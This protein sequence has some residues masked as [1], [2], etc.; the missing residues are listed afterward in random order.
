MQE[1]WKKTKK[2]TYQVRAWGDGVRS[3]EIDKKSQKTSKTNTRGRINKIRNIE[4][5]W[6]SDSVSHHREY[7]TTCEWNDMFHFDTAIKWKRSGHA[8]R[9]VLVLRRGNVKK[10][11]FLGWSMSSGPSLGGWQ[12]VLSHRLRCHAARRRHW[13]WSR[14]KDLERRMERTRP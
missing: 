8:R 7:K 13:E 4:E 12:M 11:L 6:Q 3:T 2:S 14:L 1:I 9:R 5:S 10:K